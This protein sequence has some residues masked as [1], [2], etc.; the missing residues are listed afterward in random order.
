MDRITDVKIVHEFTN[1]QYKSTCG[2]YLV[3]F[4]GKPETFIRN[5]DSIGI[6]AYYVNEPVTKCIGFIR[7]DV[8]DEFLTF[9]EKVKDKREK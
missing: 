4:R 6:V 7:D 3:T 8:K 1:E 2:V 5:G 9:L